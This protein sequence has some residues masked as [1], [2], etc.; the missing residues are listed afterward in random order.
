MFLCVQEYACVEMD[1]RQTVT[2]WWW[3]GCV[4]A[5]GAREETE[6]GGGAEE[7]TGGGGEEG[8][9]DSHFFDIHI[10]FITHN[11]AMCS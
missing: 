2:E 6:R 9:S 10:Y 11:L 5:N 8:V 7:E 3:L 4:G 1:G